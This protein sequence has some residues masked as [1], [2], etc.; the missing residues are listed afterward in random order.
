MF[1]SL[2]RR[3]ASNGFTYSQAGE[4]SYQQSGSWLRRVYAKYRLRQALRAVAL[5]FR[6]TMLRFSEVHFGGYFH[7]RVLPG[8]MGHKG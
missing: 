2:R 6:L 8:L 1:S 5:L 3:E 7:P 4:R